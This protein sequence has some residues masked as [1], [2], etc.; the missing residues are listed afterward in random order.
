LVAAVIVLVIGVH[1]PEEFRR[2][3]IWTAAALALALLAV[4]VGHLTAV[5]NEGW[6]SSGIKFSLTYASANLSANGWFYLA[7]PRFPPVYAVLALAALFSRRMGRAV[8]VGVVYFLLFWGIFLTFYAGSYNYGADDRFS[9]M[10]YPPLAVLAGIGLAWI[11]ERVDGGIQA[12]LPTRQVLV[13]TV[14]LQFLWY[15]PFVRSIGEEAWG[16]RADVDAAR[17][18]ASDLPRNSFVLTHNPG[19]FHLWGISAGQASIATAEPAYVRTVLAPR[20]AGG[21]YFHWNFWCNVADP[22]QQ[23]FCTGVLKEFPHTLLRE[24]RERDYRYGL[25]RLDL[26][27]ADRDAPR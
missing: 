15:M 18:F 2:A 1:A 10:T 26:P 4:H 21:V 3:R 19:M 8:V 5:R 9:L 24:Y 17:S 22:L 13:A 27:P 11:A 16:A 6:G 25:Y 14:C 23:S 7:D 12:R 20:Y